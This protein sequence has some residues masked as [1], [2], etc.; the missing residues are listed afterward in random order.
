MN[1]ICLSIVVLLLAIAMN[2]QHVLQVKVLDAASKKPLSF[3]SVSLKGVPHGVTADSTGLAQLK[4]SAGKNSINVSYIGYESQSVEIIIPIDSILIIEL[5]P[6]EEEEE[7]VVIQSTR[8]TRTIR[9]IP[10]RV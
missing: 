2:G 5:T 1:K 10:T 4:M 8:S 6:S 7:E 9:D 3:A